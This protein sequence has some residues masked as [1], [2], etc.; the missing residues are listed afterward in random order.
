MHHYICFS[1][2]EA[3]VMFIE[4]SDSSEL[5]VAIRNRTNRS[6]AAGLRGPTLTSTQ[7]DLGHVEPQTCF[8]ILS[9]THNWWPDPDRASALP[10]PIQLKT[11]R[12]EQ[13]NQ[14]PWDWNEDFRGR[15]ALQRQGGLGESGGRAPRRAPQ[16]EP[17]GSRGT[18]PAPGASTPAHPLSTAQASSLQVNFQSRKHA[19]KEVESE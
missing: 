18:V 5:V 3:N 6:S 15:E 8:E 7:G 4:T 13:T 14:L 1:G 16:E 10:A 9:C 12:T 2:K 11:E 19:C 17:A